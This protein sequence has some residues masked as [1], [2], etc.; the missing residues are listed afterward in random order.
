[1][2]LLNV[3]RIKLFSTRSPYWCLVAIVVAALGFAT[4]FGLVER[5][6]AAIPYLILRGVNLGMSIYMVLAAL[7]VTTEYRFGTIRNTFLAV[8]GGRRCW[9]PRRCCWP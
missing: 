7:A 6:E 3:E 1:M 9:P 8:P 2:T 4:L 5:A